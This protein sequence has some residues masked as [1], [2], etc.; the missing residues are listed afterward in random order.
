MLKGQSAEDIKAK[1][2]GYKDG[3]YG[4]KRKKTMMRMV[5]KIDDKMLND[6]ATHIGGF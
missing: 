2:M 4:G 6:L 3:S 5:E 1:L